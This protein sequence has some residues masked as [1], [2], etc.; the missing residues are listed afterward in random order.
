[1]P[2]IAVLNGKGGVGKTTI[3]VHLA[4]AYQR[5]GR[6]VLMV[7]SDHQGSLRDWIAAGDAGLPPVV[8]MDRPKQFDDLPRIADN[9]DVTIIDGCPNVESLAVAALKIADLIVIPV[10]PSPLDAWAAESLVTLIKARQDVT[11]G[12]PG[13]AFVVSRQIVGTKLAA[14]I[15][16]AMETH[17]LPIIETAVC[18][19]VAYPTSAAHGKTVFEIDPE[20]AAALEITAIAQEIYS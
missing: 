2:I 6:S 7:D 4:A 11:G 18:Q 5:A 16:S 19:R 8:A 12:T 1:M 17:G 14:D 13:A 20:G 3:S 15:R 9:Y 10:Q